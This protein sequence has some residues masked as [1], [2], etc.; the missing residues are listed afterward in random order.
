MKYSFQIR[1]FES[2]NKMS[3]YL[4]V[5]MEDALTALTKKPQK[6]EHCSSEFLYNSNLE[7][8]NTTQCLPKK[9]F[10]YRVISSQHNKKEI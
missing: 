3:Q 8:S 4:L 6:N 2:I 7:P 9:N 10:N 1:C 5:Y